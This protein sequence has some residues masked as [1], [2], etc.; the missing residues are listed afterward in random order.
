MEKNIND[1]LKELNDLHDKIK[2]NKYR[3]NSEIYSKYALGYYD[4]LR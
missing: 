2:E 1:L 3:E 4:T